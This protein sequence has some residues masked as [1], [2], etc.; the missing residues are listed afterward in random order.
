MF[1]GFYNLASGMLTQSRNLDV[2][3]NNITNSL[4][5]GYKKD[6]MTSSTFQEELMSRTGNLDKSSPQA[7]NN[8]AMMRIATGTVTNFNQGQLQET[9]NPLDMA[10]TSD[11]FFQIQT[12][13]GMVYT[14]NGSFIIDNEGYL[15]LPEVGRVMGNNG[16]LYLG[17]DDI[18]V[19]SMGNVYVAGGNNVGTLSIVN[20]D[21]TAQLEKAANG[22]FT[23]NAQPTAF[24]GTIIQKSLEQSNV[25]TVQEMVSMM[26]SQRALQSASQILK[27]Y[28]QIMNK[29]ANEIGQI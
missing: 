17:T 9:G 19:D 13:N 21:D 7:L 15:A 26:E 12:Q 24:N 23:S 8:I 25:D 5:P 2:V 18:D 6:T 1:Q 3:S 14:R 20:F 29:A 11:G 4:T 28:D 27:M 22:I 10:L 16:P